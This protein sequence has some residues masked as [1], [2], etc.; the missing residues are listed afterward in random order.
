MTS[1]NVIGGMVSGLLSTLLGG[2]RFPNQKDLILG[3]GV[4]MLTELLVTR[5]ENRNA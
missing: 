1:R 5:W 4:G 2:R 3:V